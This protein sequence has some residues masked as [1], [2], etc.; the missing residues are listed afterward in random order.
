M[1]LKKLVRDIPD[2]PIAGV[3]F[4]DISPILESPPAFHAALEQLV[5]KVDLSKIDHVVGIESRGFI[6]GA[7]IAAKFEKGF[8]PLRKAG[9]LPPPVVEKSYELEYGKATLEMRPGAGKVLIVDDVLATGGTLDAAVE[10]CA[11]A[12]Y[13]VMDISVLIDL[14]FLNGFRFNGHPVCSALVYE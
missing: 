5:R 10:L 11:K 3:L 14:R 13:Q 4:R 12:G 1:D 8:I 6:L 2:F 9:K 7:A